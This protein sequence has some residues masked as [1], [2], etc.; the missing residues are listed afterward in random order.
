MSRV[1][2]DEV[3]VF[4]TALPEL[5]RNDDSDYRVN[6]LKMLRAAEQQVIF[7]KS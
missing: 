6:T 7:K 2:A 5:D 1:A 3:S 4:Y